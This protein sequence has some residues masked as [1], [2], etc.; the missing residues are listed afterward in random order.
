MARKPCPLALPCVT[1]LRTGRASFRRFPHVTIGTPGALLMSM[2]TF[3]V[4]VFDKGIR[5]DD[6]TGHG[7]GSWGVIRSESFTVEAAD[8]K[9]AV[10]KARK[11]ATA[12]GFTKRKFSRNGN[13]ELSPAR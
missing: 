7:Q 11:V 1:L 5:N 13:A 8:R 4:F 12:L 2:T 6:P 9:E 10:S 3:S